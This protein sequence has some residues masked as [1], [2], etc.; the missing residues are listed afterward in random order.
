MSIAKPPA[1]QTQLDRLESFTLL[2]LGLHG[3]VMLSYFGG[4]LWQWIVVGSLTLFGIFVL[5]GGRGTRN[6]T[7]LCAGGI[8]SLGWLLMV[9]TAGT[10]S[11][12]LLWYFVLV[13]TYP[14]L[15]KPRYAVILPGLTSV[16]YL[17]LL[18]FLPQPIPIVVVIARAC[19]LAFIGWL[20]HALASL[21]S[22]VATES[23]QTEEALQQSEK[24]FQE[25]LES[26]PD[27][28][29]VVNR[30]GRI[31][32]INTQAK[33][34]F[35]YNAEEL[36][37]E[38]IETLL[39]GRFREKHIEHRAGY[40][41]SPRSRPMG[42]GLS[43]AG[44]RK[45]GREFP[46]EISLSPLETADGLLVTSIVRDVTERKQLEEQYYQAQKMEAIGQLAGGVAHDF[47]NLL[48][49]IN[50]FAE[51]IQV[52][53][54]PGDPIEEPV[55]KI[56][57]LGQRATDLVRQLLTFSRKQII[58]PRVI[59]LS[60]VVL[61][62]GKMLHRII[63]ENIQIQTHLSSTPWL[64]KI[65]PTQIEQ[66]IVNL[67]VN[68]RDAMPQGGRLTIETANVVLDEDY[69]AGHLEAQPGEYVLLV[70]SDTGIGISREMQAHIFEP[71]FTTKELGKG[72]GLGLATVYGIVKQ[73]GGSIFCYSEAGQGT[74][75]KIYLPRIEETEQPV[76]PSV[77]K[78]G[79]PTGHETILLAED[80]PHVR[81]LARLAL[82]GQ[83]YTVLEAQDG[84]EALQLFSGYTGP[85]HLLLTDVIM[86]GLGGIAL[87]EE[88]SQLRSDLKILFMS[89]Y[90]D[91]TIVHHGILN[92]GVAFLQKPFTPS[93][94][95]RRVRQVLDSV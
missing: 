32:L 90:T 31:V 40:Y 41:M 42:V 37:N 47:N 45:D 75:F 64:V 1:F 9:T 93:I 95:I 72:T 12:F 43:L 35:G 54:P 39:P 80:D 17:S 23:R 82:Q 49:G 63:G 51:L 89:G 19:L 26:A 13:S 8:L 30:E 21:L 58:E 53:L 66:V 29:V 50:G 22:Q 28:I 62:M 86:P 16:A 79:M 14:L 27:A 11:V 34:M 78:I 81:E 94:L 57:S 65:D 56:L 15:L 87:A 55:D 2:A 92:P 73:N 44:R 24:R 70:V 10:G 88:L 71:F 74:T 5:I 4:D 77:N 3:L 60:T 91:D 25:L 67:A 46:V 61:E 33:T 7:W 6:L 84:R 52:D 68:A 85:V 59:N 38:S 36:L 76:P 20:V 18:F 69:V 83:G 48:T